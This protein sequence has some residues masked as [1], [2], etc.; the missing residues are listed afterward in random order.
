MAVLKT[1]CLPV[2]SDAQLRSFSA[3]TQRRDGERGV[4]LRL[5]QPSKEFPLHPLPPLPSRNATPWDSWFTLKG[6]S[7]DN[8]LAHCGWGRGGQAHAHRPLGLLSYRIIRRGS[9]APFRVTGYRQRGSHFP[10]TP[11]DSPAERGRECHVM[12]MPG[13]DTPGLW[14]GKLKGCSTSLQ[15]PLSSKSSQVLSAPHLLTQARCPSPCP[16]ALPCAGACGEHAGCSSA[17]GVHSDSRPCSL[18]G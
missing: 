2:R 12:G 17:P 10:G 16:P 3:C 5:L 11:Q 18:S 13:P 14:F 4:D 6:V 9:A 7:L 8:C 15:Q 1:E